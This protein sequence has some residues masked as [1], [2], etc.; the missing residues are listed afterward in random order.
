MIDNKFPDITLGQ[1]V[2]YYDLFLTK[3][4]EYN[5]K[6]NKKFCNFNN[7]VYYS[8]RMLLSRN[9]RWRSEWSI[10]VSGDQ[11]EVTGTLKVN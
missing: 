11:A 9:G 8:S 7:N 5:K 4:Q 2:S 10:L 6:C 3:R 1:T